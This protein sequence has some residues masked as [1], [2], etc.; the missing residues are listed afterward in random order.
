MDLTQDQARPCPVCGEQPRRIEVFFTWKQATETEVLYRVGRPEGEWERA[1]DW[2][3]FT[4]EPCGHSIR[5]RDHEEWA[6]SL[7]EM[8]E[9]VLWIHGEPEIPERIE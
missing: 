5:R 6:S 4:I 9:P 3:H 2:D 8:T 1:P 7:P